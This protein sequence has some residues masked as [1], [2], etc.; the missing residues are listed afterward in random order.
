MSDSRVLSLDEAIRWREQQRANKR[1]VV[2][3]NGVFDLIHAGHVAYLEHA[4]TLG[5]VLI[6]AINSDDS[7]RRLK[8]PS[9]PY[10]P[11]EDRK[12]VIAGL[13]C[14]DAV[15]GFEELTPETVLDKLRPDIHVKSAQYRIEDLPERAV[16]EAFGGRIVLAPHA[17][18]KSTTD[19]A[20][21]IARRE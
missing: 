15:V 5:D 12:A 20:A 3:T 18:G 14:V 6:V 4:R 10:V 9:R 19:L 7:T 17:A 8:G 13:R 11:F 21:R 2:F 1:V 16:I